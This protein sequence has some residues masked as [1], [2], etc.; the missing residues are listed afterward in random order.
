MRQTTRQA[1]RRWIARF[2]GLATATAFST[3]VAVASTRLDV[4]EA[5]A[6]A[7]DG[8]ARRP[9]GEIRLAVI[10]GSSDESAQV[11]AA[12]ARAK[13][14]AS[15]GERAEES[16]A[17]VE[18]LL[19][20]VNTTLA[21]ETE[22]FSTRRILAL[23]PPAG[24]N[25]ADVGESLDRAHS[26]LAMVEQR[27][28]GARD[29]DG[30]LPPSWNELH[31]RTT[32]LRAFAAAERTFLVPQDGADGTRE[33]RQAASLLSP[34]LEDDDPRISAA[35][36]LWLAC[37]RGDEEGAGS[38]YSS[39]ELPLSEPT[40]GSLPHAFFG[41]LVTCRRLATRGHPAAAISLLQQ[42]EDRSLDWFSND[43]DRADG[44]R[45]AALVRW[46]VL[47]AW[48]RKLAEGADDDERRWC[49][50]A[51]ERIRREHFD[52]SEPTVLRLHPAVPWLGRTPAEARESPQ[53]R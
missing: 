15:A 30:A 24:V 34:S 29:A 53:E 2:A 33:R 9:L 8:D 5:G 22:P 13:D 32:T 50:E 11:R 20:A 21:L 44:E 25:A 40:K 45:A 26:W 42:L 31:R 46:Q 12:A 6:A 1:I 17:Q 38:T 14:L 28:T 49:Q 27:V 3:P 23:D 37:I 35:A 16:L 36:S 39:F 51:K 43:K 52:K 41:R 7:A 19:E 18:L 47:D 4:P 48:Q 10:D